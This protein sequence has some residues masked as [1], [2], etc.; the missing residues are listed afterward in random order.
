MSQEQLLVSRFKILKTI[1]SG[2]FGDAFLAEDTHWPQERT[3]VVKQLKPIDDNPAIYQLVKER[4]LREAVLLEELGKGHAQIPCLYAYFEDQGQ[5]Y[6][7]QEFIEGETLDHILKTQ[8]QL[9]E[10]RVETILLK[11]LDV[12]DYIQ[13]RQI[14][15]RDIKPDNIIIRQSDD[16]PVLIDFGAV[17]ESM[18]TVM[19]G[20]ENSTSSIVIGTP[21]Y[22]PPEQS[23]GRPVYSSDLYALALT[24][25]YLLTGKA[26]HELGTDPMTGEILWKQDFFPKN[27][28]LASALDQAI[29]SHS[30]Q[31]F[32]TAALMKASLQTTPDFPETELGQAKTDIPKTKVDQVLGDSPKPD[33]NQIQGPSGSKKLVW[34]GLV[35]GVVA[36]ASTAIYIQQ[37]VIAPGR[38]SGVAQ[39]E[40]DN[41]QNDSSSGKRAPLNE[42]ESTLPETQ[43]VITPS[44]PTL[45][46]QERQLAQE[47]QR[48]QDED[49]QRRQALEKQRQLEAAQVPQPKVWRSESNLT[50]LVNLN[51][52]CSGNGIINPAQTV[53]G[54]D[55]TPL[56]GQLSFPRP[57]NGGCSNGN[58]LQGNFNL[59]GSAGNCTGIVS[60]TWQSDENAFIAWDIANVGPS[61]PATTSHWEINTYPVPL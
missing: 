2:G 43:P 41:K 22:M 35:A 50:R 61:C 3:C 33:I 20:S 1:G 42:Q 6:L 32:A 30:G 31:R 24:A 37:Q 59:V 55:N 5:F 10:S 48:Q 14:I 45:E 23:I 9:S 7:V 46:E 39:E 34:A 12:L 27:P 16:M 53:F 15:H 25:I 57:K 40:L 60:V 19:G 36:I 52:I 8:G 29:H 49:A 56:T 38:N 21:G 18:G 28:V 13:Q 4:F 44:F 17:R 26:P 51:Q 54:Y 47:K 11:T 58:T